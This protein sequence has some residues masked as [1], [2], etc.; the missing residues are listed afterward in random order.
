MPAP[1]S[2]HVAIR[3]TFAAV[4]L[5]PQRMAAWLVALAVC[6]AASVPSAADEAPDEARQRG[7]RLMLL[8]A[9]G[10]ECRELCIVPG[11]PS[12]GSPTFS[13]DGAFIAMD[14]IAPGR[15]L[16]DTA[17]LVIRSD[18]TELKVL[19]DGGMP[20]WSAD[21]KQIAFSRWGNETGGVWVIDASGDP[22]SARLI[23]SAGWGIQWSPDGR[24]W[25]YQKAGQLVIRNVETGRVV[26]QPPPS[27]ALPI[28]W[29]WN[30]AWAPDSR[31]LCSVVRLPN[32]QE[33]VAV[34]KLAIPLAEAQ[35]ERAANDDG[36]LA[37]MPVGDVRLLCTGDEF[38]EDIAW[39]PNGRRVTFTGHSV[40]LDKRQVYEC[41]PTR[42]GMPQI[43]PGQTATHNVDQC[44]SP[45]G[46]KMIYVGQFD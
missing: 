45:D 18:G 9:D 5:A 31:S 12:I 11:Y 35:P 40:P 42:D 25:A 1:R 46:T 2:V 8:S 37:R 7:E 38:D 36:P 27:S 20:S 13:P 28:Q 23:D 3:L 21:G 10:E 17:L 19:G 14:G 41:D 24:F 26:R 44:W 43:L 32:G 15:Q 39:H 6:I 34:Q 16:G 22:A 4:G 29:T 30:F 33:A